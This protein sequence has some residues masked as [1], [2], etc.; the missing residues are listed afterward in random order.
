VADHEQESGREPLTEREREAL[1]I[2][3]REI[4]REAGL[5]QN[6]ELQIGLERER[7][8]LDLAKGQVVLATAFLPAMAAFAAFLENSG[9]ADTI[10]VAFTLPAA[11][12]TDAMSLLFGVAAVQAA[13]E[14]FPS[15][16]G[17]R[18]TLYCST[19]AFSL[20]VLL[21]MFYVVENL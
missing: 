9:G 18:L 10:Q 2:L 20:S 8:W 1:Q 11:F 16:P 21:F 14:S 15:P 4:V 17:R 13:A 6:R 5:D 3:A 7:V 19:G 12:Y